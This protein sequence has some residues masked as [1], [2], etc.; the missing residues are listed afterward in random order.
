MQE[1][2]TN[3]LKKIEPSVGI[4]I[5]NKN[6]YSDTIELIDSLNKITYINYEIFLCDDN[7]SDD[8]QS[9]FI[10]TYEQIKKINLIFSKKDVGL[11]GILNLGLEEVLKK[12]MDYSLVMNND[13]IVDPYFLSF[14][15]DEIEKHSKSA[16]AAGPIIYYYDKKNIIWNAGVK[17]RL[18]GF[19]N[20]GQNHL[21][22]KKW[23]KNKIVDALD[24]VYLMNN[25]V[26]KKVGMLEKD[27]FIGQEMSGWCLKAKQHGYFSMIVTESKIWHKV[28]RTLLQESKMRSYYVDRNWLI[29]LKC[30][31]PYSVYLMGLLVHLV[32]FIPRFI[33]YQLIKR[34]KFLMATR[35]KAIIDS[36]KFK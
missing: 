2:S 15:V 18:Q 25:S 1:K 12:N 31:Q 33:Y 34:K 29:L 28:S 24:A 27:F 14:L 6:G 23:E 9:K 17:F 21:Y 19:K 36:F 8:S 10:N 20:L 35:I 22:S 16:A 26:V 3:K 11:A 32:L 5:A 4:I 13:M 30:T 7:S